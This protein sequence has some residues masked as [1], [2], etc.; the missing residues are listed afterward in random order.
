MM[1]QDVISSAKNNLYP[2]NITCKAACN[3]Y[4]L[5]IITMIIGERK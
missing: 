4:K 2:H 1:Y 3:C 5:T